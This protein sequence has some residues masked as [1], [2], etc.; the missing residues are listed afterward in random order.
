MLIKDLLKI[1]QGALR[2]LIYYEYLFGEFTCLIK[3][4]KKMRTIYIY[5]THFV[6]IYIYT[7]NI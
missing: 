5:Y 7:Y 1:S 3:E 6:Y 2:P 4:R